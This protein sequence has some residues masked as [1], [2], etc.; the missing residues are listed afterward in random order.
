M[1]SLAS[2]IV[3]AR[4]G[5]AKKEF[6]PIRAMAT[7]G[8]MGGCLLISALNA[9]RS[10]LAGYSAA[11]VWLLVFAL[12]FW[13]PV[14]AT[15]PAAQGLTWTQRFGLDA[16]SLLKNRD[17]R[18]VFLATSLFMIPLAAFYPYTPAH[19]EQLGL[20]HTS[21]WMSLAQVTETIA[22]L[23]IGG[24][25]LR[26]R[27]KWIIALGLA[28]GVLRFALCATNTRWGVLGGVLG[29]GGSFTFIF[30]TAQ[31]YLDQRIDPA[32][33]ARGQ[34]LMTL[35]NGGLGNLI[36]YLSVGGWFTYC[37]RA[38]E[39]RWSLFWSVVALA[40]AAVLGLFLVAYR[41]RGAGFTRHEDAR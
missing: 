6:G 2:T 31:I 27:I 12:T 1:W 29:H 39:A 14:V 36:G 20:M 16:L 8:W 21:A 26:W 32:W 25:L 38:G 9:D 4:L 7:L 37:M 18:G 3:F 15:S 34:A 41:G 33:R 5:D 19:L 28:F 35:M 24:L 30:I 13:L 17:H 10:T 23:L 40:A 22:M 11:I